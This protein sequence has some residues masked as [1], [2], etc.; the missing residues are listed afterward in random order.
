MSRR[1][2][3]V[4]VIVI[5]IFLIKLLIGFVLVWKFGLFGL[6]VFGMVVFVF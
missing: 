1:Y 5:G 3:V 4:V 2:V 6:V